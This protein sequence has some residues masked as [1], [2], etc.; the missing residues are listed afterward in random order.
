[1][2]IECDIGD[3]RREG[4]SLGNLGN[5]AVQQTDYAAAQVYY[6]QALSMFQP[7][8][9]RGLDSWALWGL[10]NAKL[11]LGQALQ[12]GLIG[13]SPN[14]AKVHQSI[15]YK[16]AAAS[17]ASPCRRLGRRWPNEF[18]AQPEK[19]EHPQQVAGQVGRVGAANGRKKLNSLFYGGN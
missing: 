19:E 11:G 3:Q 18:I 9:Y 6:Q 16:L 17:I 15:N 12:F 1:M 13:P 4:I 2:F 5:I 10:G 14:K 7:I 8:T